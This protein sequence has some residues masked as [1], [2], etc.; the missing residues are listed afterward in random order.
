M[1]G[2]A[3]VP[4]LIFIV[5]FIKCK[6][7]ALTE[8]VKADEVKAKEPKVKLIEINEEEIKAEKERENEVKEGVE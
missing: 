1:G 5:N 4:V 2:L 7:V 8:K 3:H 6:F